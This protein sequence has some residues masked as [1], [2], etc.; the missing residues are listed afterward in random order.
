MRDLWLFFKLYSRH[1][2]MLTLGVLLALITLIASLGLLTLS[3]WFITATSLAG[4]ATATAKLF[5]FFTPASG[6]RGFSILRT[7]SRYGER[8]ISHDATFRLL[9]WLREWFFSKLLPLSLDKAGCYRKGDLLNR[10]VTDVDTLDQLYLRL[11]S[12]LLS[13]LFLSLILA[14]FLSFFSVPLAL[15]SLVVM[16]V[17]I[18]CMPLLFFNLGDKVGRSLGEKQR[19]FRQQALDHL[20][21]MAEGLVFGYYTKSRRVLQ[22]TE[23]KLQAD[24]HSMAN[25]EG[26]GSF[27]FVAG[28]GIAALGM[29]WLASGELQ[30]KHISGPVM[31]MMV[32]AM[33]AGFEA[34]MPLPAAFQF[35]SHTRQAARRLREVVDE[36]PIEFVS[37]DDDFTVKG[38]ICFSD[39]SFAYETKN[40]GGCSTVNNLYLDIAAGQHIALL[41]KTGCGKSTLIRLINRGLSPSQGNIFLDGRLI[42][43]VT[44]KT[45]YQSIT[46]V[47]QHTHIFSAT[48]RDNLLLAAPDADNQQLINAITRAGLNNIAAG[49][50]QSISDVLDLWIGQ[51]GVS[52]SGGE[53]RRV[54]M[55][56]ALLKPAPILIMDEPTEGLD[57]DSE[58]ALLSEVLKAFKDSTVVMITHKKVVLEKMDAV[59]LMTDGC[60]KK[61]STS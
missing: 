30:L 2:G 33:L 8:L 17:W 49:S 43:S 47:P 5:N 57:R 54:A 11:L 19:D 52:L 32:F 28:S 56:R 13:A 59:Y 38:G 22:N 35:L 4:L 42:Q 7:A 61:L 51:G 29:L 24:Q 3:G 48:L 21:G 23:A 50:Y 20:Q 39:V 10:V 18:S 53:Q 9:A 16:W 58:K 36:N 12:P 34:L 15:F 46:F 41:G 26:L 1:K 14:I 44:E 40:K 60:I 6:V 27:L 45:L 55:A 37:I 31:A 25:I